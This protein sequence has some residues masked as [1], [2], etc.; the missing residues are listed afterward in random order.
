[1][2]KIS[3]R[4]I[5][6]CASPGAGAESPIIWLL[7]YLVAKEVSPAAALPS[8]ALGCPATPLAVAFALLSTVKDDDD[9]PV[10]F[11]PPFLVCPKEA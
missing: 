3:K 11:V 1:M 9:A 10:A 7:A 6:S 2:M 4:T 8:A 5:M